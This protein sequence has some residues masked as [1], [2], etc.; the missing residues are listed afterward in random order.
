MDRAEA[1]TILKSQLDRLRT[2]SYGE[3]VALIG[4]HGTTEVKGPSGVTYQV[5]LQAFWDD[6]KKPNQVLR[7]MGG[8]DD[9][10]LRAYFPMSDSFLMAPDGVFVGE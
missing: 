1:R 9:G 6:P 7:I 4:V 8:I 3:L 5:Q 2:K 10:G